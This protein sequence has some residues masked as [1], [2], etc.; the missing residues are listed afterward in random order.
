M[1]L[2]VCIVQV[3]HQ[4]KGD[5]T[6]A[7]DHLLG[8]FIQLLLRFKSVYTLRNKWVIPPKLNNEFEK[9]I[10]RFQSTLISLTFTNCFY[11]PLLRFIFHAVMILCRTS[12]IKQS[13]DDIIHNDFS[14]YVQKICFTTVLDCHF[15]D[16]KPYI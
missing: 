10:C 9:I 2:T 13:A 5:V 14:G 3:N 4:M 8:P 7:S 1:N 11:G 16:Q 12:N 6:L 15:I